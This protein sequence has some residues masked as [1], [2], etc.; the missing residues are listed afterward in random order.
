MVTETVTNTIM[1]KLTVVRDSRHLSCHEL[2]IRFQK[3][4]KFCHF[5]SW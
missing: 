2:A 5:T 1:L 4:K 3:G